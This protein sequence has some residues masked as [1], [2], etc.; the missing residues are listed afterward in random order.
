M[1]LQMCISM[2]SYRRFGCWLIDS[3]TYINW[4]WDTGHPSRWLIQRREKGQTC[5]ILR[6]DEEQRSGALGMAWWAEV[7]LAN[8]FSRTMGLDNPP[9]NSKLVLSKMDLRNIRGL[10]SR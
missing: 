5:T 10:H 6:R 2:F 3:N 8:K 1:D 7:E 9:A 4:D